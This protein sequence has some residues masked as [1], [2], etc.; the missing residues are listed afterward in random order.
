MKTKTK[1]ILQ[2]HMLG[3]YFLVLA[4]GISVSVE[5]GR[6]HHRHHGHHYGHHHHYDGYAP[7]YAPP[8]VYGYPPNVAMD[9]NTRSGHFFLSY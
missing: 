1:Y 5:A 7:V 3:V 9:I 8:P 6:G 4:T 2:P